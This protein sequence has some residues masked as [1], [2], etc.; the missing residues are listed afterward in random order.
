MDAEDDDEIKYDVALC[1]V[2]PR[3]ERRHIDTVSRIPAAMPRK[4]RFLP[5]ALS[6]D[7]INRFPPP[8][9]GR[10]IRRAALNIAVIRK[11]I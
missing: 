2:S 5:T 3:R 7:E 9:T 10:V 6:P 1:T 4:E 11:A 8:S